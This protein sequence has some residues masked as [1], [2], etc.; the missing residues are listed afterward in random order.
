MEVYIVQPL[1]YEVKEENKF[2]ELKQVY[3]KY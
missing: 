1:D 3:S 2:L